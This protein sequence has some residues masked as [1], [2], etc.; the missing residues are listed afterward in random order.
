MKY[1]ALKGILAAGLVAMLSTSCHHKDLYE[2]EL[3]YQEIEVVFDWRNAP[4]ANPESMVLYMFEEKGAAPIRFVFSGR[5]GGTIR[6]P[7]GK[8]NS[9]AMNADDTDWAYDTNTGDI[10]NF[11]TITHEVHPVVAGSTYSAHVSRAEDDDETTKI[12]E[13]P[14]MLWSDR[15]DGFQLSSADYNTRKVLT[16]YPEEAVCHYTVKV[17]DVENIDSLN[18]T[19]VDAILSGMAEGFMHGQQVSGKDNVTMP[20]VLD[21]DAPSHELDGSFL[22]FGES[23]QRNHSDILSLYINLADGSRW[24]RDFDVTAQVHN[25]PDPHHVTIIISGVELPKSKGEPG[26]FTA[27]VNPWQQV[28]IHLDM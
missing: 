14:G 20:F 12:V 25:A 1:S 23:P 28:D 5:D 18:G 21:A 27:D 17:L 10:D 16:L 26:G 24:Y 13:T 8:Y 3:S 15:V 11:E 6:L 2:E 22:T 4:D 9:I 19:K 7:Y